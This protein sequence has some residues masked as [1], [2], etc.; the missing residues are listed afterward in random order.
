MGQQAAAAAHPP[1]PL[2]STSIL[3]QQAGR[4]TVAGSRAAW[5]A[6]GPVGHVVK[7]G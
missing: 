7:Q 1:R 5:Q 6:A 2:I 3:G 4:P